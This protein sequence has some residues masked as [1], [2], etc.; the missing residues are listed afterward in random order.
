[1]EMTICNPY[2]GSE[3]FGSIITF[4]FVLHQ[5][6]RKNHWDDDNRTSIQYNRYNDKTQDVIDKNNYVIIGMQAIKL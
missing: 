5:K 3:I 6:C 1:M 4:L 2:P